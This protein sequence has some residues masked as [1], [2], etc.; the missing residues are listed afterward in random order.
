MKLERKTHKD[1]TTNG[2][3]CGVKY[4]WKGLKI[5]SPINS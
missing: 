5:L 4:L 1:R 3:M 2:R